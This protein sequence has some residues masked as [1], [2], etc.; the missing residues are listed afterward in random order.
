MVKHLLGQYNQELLRDIQALISLISS[1]QVSIELEPYKDKI[2]NYSE[3]LLNTVNT[4]LAL[5]KIG[6]AT[7]INDILS[8]T[9][10]ATQEIRLLSSMRVIPILNAKNEDRLCLATIS[11]LH[12]SLPETKKYPP[13]FLS[14]NC[15][16]RPFQDIA[17]L[18]IFPALEQKYLLYLP[19]LFHEYGH[20]LYQV[21][22]QEMDDLV[23]DLQA[24][25]DEILMPMSQRNDRFSDAMADKRQMIA[26]TWYSWA[27][28]LFCDV[29]G[30]TI[31]GPSYLQAF[32]KFLLMR[33]LGNFYR[34]PPDLKF[35]SHPVT[36]LRIHYICR[37]AK[38]TG[39]L[40]L[41]SEIENQWSLIARMMDVA[42]DYH[43]FYDNSLDD[44][45]NKTLEDMLIEANPRH[46]TKTDAI[47]G[48]WNPT[49]DSPIRLFSWAWQMYLND[50]QNY[51]TWEENQ[52]EAL[53]TSLPK[54]QSM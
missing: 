10:Q 2:L 28:E 4:N 29:V 6:S 19:L 22:K 51:S 39:F 17:P 24:E 44:I 3:T 26:Y 42:E 48:E 35:S 23:C 40:K 31:G 47:G 20:F 41:A 8:R 54:I 50:F 49:N 53:I 7:I 11:W 34:E 16:I 36:W 21:H 32:S 18:Y 9:Q 37:R 30:F 1:S 52:V 45:I 46:F 12:Q 15:A 25:I 27:Q 38:E 14:G 13:V 43:G 5:L 33:D